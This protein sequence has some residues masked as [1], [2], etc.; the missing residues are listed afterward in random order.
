MNNPYIHRHAIPPESDM[1]FGRQAE[2][3]RILGMLRA[4]DPQ[5][6]SIVGE[7]RIGKSSIAVRVFHALKNLDR[8]VPV[9]LDCGGLA[10]DCDTREKFFG[11]LNRK[12]REYRD[13]FNGYGDALFTDYSSFEEFIEDETADGYR[14]V[15]FMDEFEKL[16]HMPFADNSFFSNLRS[17]A[18]RFETRLAYVTI[19]QSS[20]KGLTHQVIDTSEFWNIFSSEIIGLLDEKSIL[21]M[22]RY[23]FDQNGMVLKQ[24]EM[25]A[26]EYYA[27]CFPFFNQIV[28]SHVF[29]AKNCCCRVNRDG[30]EAELLERFDSLWEY[31]TPEE[32]K[33]LVEWK[34]KAAQESFV[35][36]ELHARG[37]LKKHN[38]NYQPFSPF[39]KRLLEKRF[40]QSQDIVRKKT[41][42]PKKNEKLIF[43]CYH[44]T[45][46]K[47]VQEIDKRL[48]NSG[49]NTWLDTN[50]LLPGQKKEMIIK[51]A[52]NQSANVLLFL[53]AEAM[54]A[55]GNYQ[56]Q[57]KWVAD[58]CDEIPETDIGVIPV[59]IDACEVPAYLDNFLPFRYYEDHFDKL[60]KSL[61]TGSI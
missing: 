17:L 26:I 49:F 50:D 2:M 3:N 31:R 24:K 61:S 42:R 60:I 1:F 20:L 47:I 34:T 41:I 46:R 14:F 36:Q 48:R 51:Q 9:F 11:K 28:C 58:Y 37:I 40:T 45:N 54:K 8:M 5:C 7:R 32:K 18:N 4:D 59:L 53:S 23:G 30:L 10:D 13:Q 56:K 25:N 33:L 43:C 29:D 44:E 57:I 12:F 38:R 39:F 35:F 16:P 52:I 27:G 6:V 21:E 22:R 19:S 15:I 55:R